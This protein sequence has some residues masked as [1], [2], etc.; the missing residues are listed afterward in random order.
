MLVSRCV[1]K[2]GSNI[3]STLGSA[4]PRK[5]PRAPAFGFSRRQLLGGGAAKL[6]A[7]SLLLSKPAIAQS[8]PFDG[9]VLRGAAYQ[10]RFFTIL[11]GY[12]PE[13]E[14]KTGM[15]VDLQLWTFPLYNQRAGQELSSGG[16]A[17]DFVNVTFFLA[18]QWVEAGYLTNLDE[19]TLDP[20]LTPP[21]WNPGD[22][23]DG[24][25]LPYRDAKGATYGYAWEG[26][27]MVMGL[28]RMDL[29]E[30]KG[31]KIPTT[32]DEL[33][34]VC[35]EIH[36][37]GEVNGFVS[38]HLHHWCLMPYLHGFGGNAF[39][40]PPTDVTPALNSPEA[41]QAVEFYASL[42]KRYAPRDVRSYT[43]EQARQSL[44]TGHSNVFIHS[45]SWVT[46]ALL[47]DESRARETTCIVRMPAGPV[48]DYPAANSQGLGIPKNAK[49]RAAAWEFLRWA[50]SPEMAMRI[51]NEHGHS[52]ICRR[53]II[54]SEAYRKINTVNGQDL[55]ALYLEVLE[56]PA[57]GNNYMSYRTVKEFPVVGD[58]INKA[59]EQV[60]SGRMTSRDA[61]NAA[62]A[63]AIASLQRG[64]IKL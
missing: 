57:R 59:V 35:A 8:K 38:W 1:K 11:Q 52:T 15:K 12:I 60:A 51:V 43:E 29:M 40:N 14:N 5:I 27:S 44:L 26:G 20:N 32:F 23:V 13:F 54:G 22:F 50:L 7:A 18:A 25:Q 53:S 31:L 45:S 21:D 2:D 33:Q 30:R 42:L 62:Q 64:S 9:V 46:P 10:H 6:A 19:F 48:H 37:P 4:M 34:H 16:S 36:V 3:A 47:S 39:Q 49:N 17:F 63:Q 61:M 56:L 24:A 55:G 41:V 28:S 58:A